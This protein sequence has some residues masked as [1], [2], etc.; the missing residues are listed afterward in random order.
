MAGAL[1]D[2]TLELVNADGTTVRLNDN[3]KSGQQA[4]LKALGIEPTRDKEAALIQAL[5]AGNYAIVRG[6][7]NTTGV[8]LV[9]VYTI[10]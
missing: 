3:W 8:G 6:V 10:Q 9:E 1:A 4:E 2:P 5:P 7:T